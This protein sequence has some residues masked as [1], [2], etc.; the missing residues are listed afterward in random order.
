MTWVRLDDDFPS[1]RKVRRC[2]DGAFRFHISGLC[3]ASRYLTDG[4]ISAE[5]AEL[6]ADD[7][8]DSHDPATLKDVL[9][10]LTRRGMWHPAQH[11][12]PQCPTR[13]DDGWVIHDYLDMNPSAEQVQRQRGLAAKR[14]RR[15]RERGVA[16]QQIG[17]GES[18]PGEASSRNRHAVTDA[19]VTRESRLPTPT[20]TP[21]PIR[22]KSTRSKSERVSAR[23]P[24]FER[25]WANYPRKEAKGAAE[26]AWAAAI[27]KTDP[28][29]IVSAAE[30]YRSQPGR[31]ARYTAHPATWLNAERWSDEPAPNGSRTSPS[32]YQPYR[33]D[34]DADYNAEL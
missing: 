8:D 24:D 34:P 33:D 11:A 22:T 15:A 10:E 20:P 5:D 25:F 30:R 1:H 2:S 21:T 12:C 27:K 26:K 23:D 28:E 19:S 13:E 29:A 32:G 16:V 9:N 14:Q 6:I 31:E 7:L 17:D 3:W 18:S 4:Y